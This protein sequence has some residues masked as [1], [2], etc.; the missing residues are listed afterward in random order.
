ME[1]SLETN[2]IATAELKNVKF[3]YWAGGPYLSLIRL[4]LQLRISR[5]LYPGEW[6]ISALVAV[7]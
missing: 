3:L 5:R 4:L 2:E 1:V 7:L 6:V